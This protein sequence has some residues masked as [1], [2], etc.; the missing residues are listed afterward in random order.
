VTSRFG[1]C[2]VGDHEN[3]RVKVGRATCDCDCKN[4]GTDQRPALTDVS[5]AFKEIHD[6]YAKEK[7]L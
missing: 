4:H 2:L 5:P 6:K 3:C 7:N 1:W